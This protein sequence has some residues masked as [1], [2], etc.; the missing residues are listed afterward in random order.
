MLEHSPWLDFDRPTWP[1]L[2]SDLRCEVAI[3]GA[4]ISGVATLYYLLTSTQKNVVLFKK[5]EWLAVPRV[6]MQVLL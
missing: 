1:S 3:V 4:G 2:S 6:T 5:I